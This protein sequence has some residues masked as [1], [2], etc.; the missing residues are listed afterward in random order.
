[1]DEGAD[2]L[3]GTAMLPPV[4]SSGCGDDEDAAL[5]AGLEEPPQLASAV[6]L[7]CQLDAAITERKALEERLRD[8]QTEYQQGRETMQDLTRRA[9]VLLATA[10]LE[11]GRKAAKLEQAARTGMP[12]QHRARE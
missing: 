8:L 1:M 4:D 9:C 11:V 2:E 5:Y 7:Q 6:D 10:R 3:Y 12:H